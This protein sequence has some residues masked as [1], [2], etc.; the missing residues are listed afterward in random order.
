MCARD[1]RGDLRSR[2]SATRRESISLLDRFFLFF[3]VGG[4][5]VASHFSLSFVGSIENEIEREIERDF[6][7]KSITVEK[8]VN[9]VFYVATKTVRVTN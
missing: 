7:G 3:R 4:S 1:E 5:G 8:S 6:R 2:I 9:R